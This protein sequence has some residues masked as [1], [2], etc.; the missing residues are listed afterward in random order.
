MDDIA[1]LQHLELVSRVCTELENHLGTSDKNAAEFIIDIAKN[2][3]TFNK[4]KAALAEYGL[5]GGVSY[6]R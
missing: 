6:F 5:D 4:F 3:P 1:Q 2:N